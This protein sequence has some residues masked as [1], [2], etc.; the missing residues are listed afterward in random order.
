MGHKQV[1]ISGFGPFER[2]SDNSSGELASA[3]EREPVAG[4]EKWP[5]RVEPCYA[6]WRNAGTDCGICLATCPFS[7]RNSRLHNLVRMAIRR[8]PW[9]H[10][11]ALWL[12]DLV[13]GRDW[14][15]RS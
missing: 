3:L 15:P 8:F 7:H 1:F 5:T 11:P 4:V 2:V 12:D 6:M 13:Y 14:E 10:R 9:S